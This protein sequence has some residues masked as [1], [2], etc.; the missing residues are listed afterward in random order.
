ML[1]L[2]TMMPPWPTWDFGINMNLL[3]VMINFKLIVNVA[4]MKINLYTNQCWLLTEGSDV[5]AVLTNGTWHNQ[6]FKPTWSLSY[7]GILALLMLMDNDSAS[8]SWGLVVDWNFYRLCL[9][10]GISMY[11]TAHKL[12]SFTDLFIIY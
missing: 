3:S 10:M 4:L 11:G 7:N 9:G 6:C 8:L 12:F 1:H 2:S 5:W